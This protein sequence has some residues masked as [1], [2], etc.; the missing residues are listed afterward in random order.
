MS[1]NYTSKEYFPTWYKAIDL[2][3]TQ[4][5]VDNRISVINNII[6]EED[7][8]L[9]LDIVR[10]AYGIKL[11]ST[12]SKILFENKFREKDITFPIV[13][14]DNIIKVLAEIS[15]CF[16]F[17]SKSRLSHL[18]SLAVINANFF[19]KYTSSQVPYYEFAN[20][21]D[22]NNESA[23]DIDIDE[24]EDNL[25]EKANTFEEDVEDEE[26]LDST[27]SL[28]LIKAVTY[29]NHENKKLK[30]ETNILWWLFGQ[31]SKSNNAYFSEIGLS[32]MVIASAQELF[33]LSS[34]SGYR[35][36]AKH[37]LYKVLL[38]S[39][40]NKP[41]LKILSLSDSIT[42]ATAHSKEK[43][44]HLGNETELTPFIYA[45]DL[46]KKF[47]DVAV[48]KAAFN[49]TLGTGVSDKKYKPEDLAFQFYREIIFLQS[50][51]VLKND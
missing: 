1:Q 37:I 49:K 33:E 12:E 31:H 3:V 28:N 35:S 43:L 5:L 15:L 32:K 13:S 51:Q 29:L 16:L 7:I 21:V 48:W 44:L 19:E 10:L 40:D 27:D 25:L 47:T 39:N 46:E 50:L 34:N 11:E 17:E 26:A 14:N 18:I 22:E 8:T 30:E 2:T 20:N 41:K 45:L 4:D 6:N 36:S 23:S 9:W 24:I 42:E 38:I